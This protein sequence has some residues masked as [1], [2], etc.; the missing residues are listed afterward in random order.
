MP[1]E[2]RGCCPAL[3]SALSV[4]SPPRSPKTRFAFPCSA[5]LILRSCFPC[6]VVPLL[7][8]AQFEPAWPPD[9]PFVSGEL[10]SKGYSPRFLLLKAPQGVLLLLDLSASVPFF[11]RAL[12]P[13]ATRAGTSTARCLLFSAYV[14][15]L[16]NAAPLFP[17]RS[18]FRASSLSLLPRRQTAER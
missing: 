14:F 17:S 11:S 12:G 7:S 4:L 13:S 1:E 18:L 8:S 6:I 2:T 3:L 16:T 9:A 5:R 10:L 15:L